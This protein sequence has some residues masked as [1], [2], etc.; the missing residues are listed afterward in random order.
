MNIFNVIS[1]VPAALAAL[2]DMA[3]RILKLHANP[4]F[5]ALMNSDPEIKADSEAISRDARDIQ[6]A[7]K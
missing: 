4:K 2:K 7:F 5:Q 3:A 1:H 6:N